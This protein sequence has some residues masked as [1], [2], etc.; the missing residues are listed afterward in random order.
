[1]Y[2]N[3]VFHIS[4]EERKLDGVFTLCMY[5]NCN[6]MNSIAFAVSSSMKIEIC[7]YFIVTYTLISVLQLN[8][9]IVL[10]VPDKNFRSDMTFP[11][12]TNC[13]LLLGSNDNDTCA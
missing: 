9:G 3:I 2:C 6:I 5:F 11:S 12:R 10:Y 8:V 1:M 7:L 13:G 4:C